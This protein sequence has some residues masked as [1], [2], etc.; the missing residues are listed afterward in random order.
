LLVQYEYRKKGIYKTNF[1][2]HVPVN[3]EE[4][5]FAYLNPTESMQSKPQFYLF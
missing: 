3:K 1:K 5:T 2:N 4:M